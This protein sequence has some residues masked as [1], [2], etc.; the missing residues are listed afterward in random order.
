MKNRK[1]INS[2][3]FLFIINFPQILSNGE[4]KIIAL[5]GNIQEIYPG[6][7]MVAYKDGRI[8]S[9]DRLQFPWELTFRSRPYGNPTEIYASSFVNDSGEI[10][11]YSVATEP[12]DNYLPNKDIIL[13]IVTMDQNEKTKKTILY[14]SSQKN[15]KFILN[16]KDDLIA[17]EIS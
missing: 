4:I 17:E 12:L 6:N 7:K 3:V 2:L 9:Y 1:I 11:H 8:I 14:L 15:Y 10:I 5:F 13:S 16:L